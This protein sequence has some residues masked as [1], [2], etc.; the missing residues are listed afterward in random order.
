MPLKAVNLHNSYLP[1]NRGADPNFW[2]FI[3]DSPKGVTIH[4]LDEGL[5]TGDIIIQKEVTF[6]SDNE[7]L[8]TTYEKLQSAIQELFKCHWEKIK[9]G[10]CDSRKQKGK[11]SFHK[12]KDKE[13]LSHLLADGWNTRISFLEEYAAEIQMNTQFWDK[14]DREIEEIRNSSAC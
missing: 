9:T 5:D 12:L 8:A 6:K 10:D 1:W 11:G 3:E 7:T 4:Y 2:S 13:C 14:Y